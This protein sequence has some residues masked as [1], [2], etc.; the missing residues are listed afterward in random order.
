[1]DNNN[2]PI[3]KIDASLV[4]GSYGT[5]WQCFQFQ[6]QNFESLPPAIIDQ[7]LGP[8]IPFR[9]LGCNWSV[10]IF[11]GGRSDFLGGAVPVVSLAH[12]LA[13]P[14]ITLEMRA[15][16]APNK[17]VHAIIAD[18]EPHTHIVECGRGVLTALARR[19]DILDNP[20][21]YLDNGTYTITLCM[22]DKGGQN[23]PKAFIPKNPCS[24]S[25]LSMLG[26]NGNSTAD[27]VFEVS[28]GLDGDSP[29]RKSA[30]MFVLRSCAPTLAALCEDYP[31]MTPVPI[32]NMKPIIFECLIWHIYGGEVSSTLLKEQSKDIIIAADMYGVSTLKVEAEVAYIQSIDINIDNVVDNFFFA[33]TKKC[34]LLKEK[35]MEYLVDNAQE[36]LDKLDLKDTP[37]SST[38]FRD[39]MTAVALGKNKNKDYDGDDPTK[40][41]TMCINVLRRKLSER[42]LEIDGTREML[43]AS[44]EE[45]YAKAKS[46]GEK[47]KRDEETNASGAAENE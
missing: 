1:M 41:K 20:N 39:F 31:N 6:I 9:C 16:D 8:P 46:S 10:D 7:P 30:H 3:T 25:I 27:V 29:V 13:G 34:A 38:L 36:V 22:K 47:R 4:P 5:G 11:L 40:V 15:T 35:V 17:I 26:P 24:K 14:T 28:S 2:Y 45:S 42:G 12:V 21:L 19:Q 32:D 37:E 18:Q 44:L 43:V 33:D 23:M